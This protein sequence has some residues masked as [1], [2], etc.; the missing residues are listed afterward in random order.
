MS[1]AQRFD[2]HS[3]DP[4]GSTIYVKPE[5][6]SVSVVRESYWWC[7]PAGDVAMPPVDP[8]LWER[9]RGRVGVTLR[10]ATDAHSPARRVYLNARTFGTTTEQPE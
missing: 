9:V 4:G 1:H 2:W 10:E 3:R 8:D 5:P 6:D 7:S